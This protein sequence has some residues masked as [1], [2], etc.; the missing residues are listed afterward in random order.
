MADDIGLSALETIVADAAVSA[1]T[2]RV[3]VGT[4]PQNATLPAI[5]VDVITN[6]AIEHLGGSALSVARVRVDTYSTTRALASTLAETVRRNAMKATHKGT[7]GTTNTINTR[8]ITLTAGPY[9]ERDRPLDGSDQWR[10]FVRTEYLVT[11]V[12]QGPV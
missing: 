11:Y 10:E 4:L 8:E 12:Q 2:T 1:I 6:N 9:W 5:V 7:L 3:Y